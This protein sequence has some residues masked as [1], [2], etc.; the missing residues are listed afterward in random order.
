MSAVQLKQDVFGELTD[1]DGKKK[2][3]KR[4][5]WTNKR[6]VVV[7]LI[8]YGGYITSIKIPDRKGNVEDVV[9]GYEN[10]EG[11]FSTGNA[12][13]GCTVGRGA[14]RIGK[15][16]ITIEGVTYNLS[17]NNGLNHLHGGNTGFDKVVFDHYVNG[18]Q[19]ILS[20]HS[21]DLEEGYPGDVVVNV[22]FELTDETEFLIDYKARTT[23]PTY[24]NMT[25][26]SYFNLA[27]HNKGS[28]ELYKHVISINA[29]RV[30]EVDSQGIPTGNLVPVSGTIF[31]L[32]IPRVIGDVVRKVPNSPGYDHNYCIAKGSQQVDT[33]VAK[34]YHPESGRVLEVYSDQPGVQFYTGNFLPE[35]DSVKGKDGQIY[36]KHGAFCLEP[37]IFPDAINHNHFGKAILYPGEQ[38]THTSKY[39]FF[40][41]N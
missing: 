18:N 35:D 30:T 21:S 28:A 41:E 2:T 37:Q 19:V 16:K 34:V 10:L 1:H 12:Y 9:I 38:Y 39:K 20:Y 26:H 7:Q 17:A 36:K 11:Y 8:T 23:K 31:D 22:T 15:S 3:I 27:G 29:D 33:F 5:T 25:N 13:F 24:V 32:R 14:N 40:T 4:F 6:G